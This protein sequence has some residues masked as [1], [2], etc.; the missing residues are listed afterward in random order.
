MNKSILITGAGGGIGSEIALQASQQGYKIGL[1]DLNEK[2]LHEVGLNIPNSIVLPADVTDEES[3]NKAL[4]AFGETPSALVNCAGIVRFGSLLEQ[5][6]KDFKDVIEV[7]LLSSFIVGCAVAKL[8]EKEGQGNIINISSISGGKHPAIHSGAY[9]A[10]KAGL[11]MLSEQMSLEWGKLGIRVNTISPGFIDAGMSSSHYRDKTERK[12]R[13]SMVPIQRI[14]TAD[15]IAKVVMFLLSEDSS[16]IHGEN[17]LV[18][19]GVMN[20]VLA[21]IG[22]N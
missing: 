13:E 7:N 14:G 3:I 8:M 16:Y 22:R 4:M 1:I 17:I 6:V 19:G 18:D 11:V 20:S 9:A 5:E 21:N 10:A 15:D 2:Q 12:K